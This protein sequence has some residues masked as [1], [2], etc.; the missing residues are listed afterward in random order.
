MGTALAGGLPRAACR[1][2]ATAKPS[3]LRRPALRLATQPLPCKAGTVL[4]RR[5]VNVL[6]WCR[7]G[8]E[9]LLVVCVGGGYIVV[10]VGSACVLA[11][12]VAH[13]TSV[14]ACWWTSLTAPHRRRRGR[15]SSRRQPGQRR[16][17]HVVRAHCRRGR[18]RGVAARG[19]RGRR[20]GRGR[21][22]RRRRA[23]RATVRGGRAGPGRRSAGGAGGAGGRHA[24]AGARPSGVEQVCGRARPLG[25]VRAWGSGRDRAAADAASWPGPCVSLFGIALC[26]RCVQRPG[27]G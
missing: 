22:G 6:C 19:R 20:R 25:G 2:T 7:G 14:L 8:C 5:C 24:A 3:L 12:W 13:R 4:V 10:G 16:G 15:G 23:E 27:L 9:M 21:G 18:A 1:A 11:E 17:L 26:M